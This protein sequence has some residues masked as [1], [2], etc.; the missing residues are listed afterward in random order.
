MFTIALTHA[1]FHKIANVIVFQMLKTSFDVSPH[2]P[3]QG[4]GEKGYYGCA[5]SH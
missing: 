3:H 5:F 2:V 1:V 4:Q